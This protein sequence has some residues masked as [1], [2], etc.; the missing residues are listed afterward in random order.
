MATSPVPQ[1]AREMS[2][3]HTGPTG[4]GVLRL[5]VLVLVVVICWQW[6]TATDGGSARVDR[7]PGVSFFEEHRGQPA[8][9]RICEETARRHR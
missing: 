1:W 4:G 7:R 5:A 8:W 6:F 3:T 2:P 9:D